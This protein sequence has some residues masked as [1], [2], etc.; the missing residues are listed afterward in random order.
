[1]TDD[2]ADA[3]P[4]GRGAGRHGPHRPALD[5]A[6]AGCR[7]A[8]RRT[9]ARVAL[10]AR[11]RVAP[12]PDA[13]VA[14]AADP[15]AADRQPRRDRAAH[16][17]HGAAGSGSA[18]IG[19]HEAGRPAAGRGRPGR[20]RCLDY[21]DADAILDA[22]RRARRRRDPPRLRLPGRE[23]RRSPRP[24]SMPGWPG[25]GR[26][27]PPSRRWATRRRRGARPSAHGVPVVPGYDG[28]AQDD[29]T[30]AGRGGAR[31]AIPLLVK[32][33][34]GGGGKGMRVVRDADAPAGGAGVS[35]ARGAA[36]PSATIGSSWSAARAARATSRSR[37]CSTRHGHGVHLGE[38]DCSAQR[39]HQKI[40][41]ES[42][43][44]SVDA[45][46]ARAARGG[47]AAGGGARSAT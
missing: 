1:M 7:R 38:R 34:A 44:P 32:P 22:A 33:A 41:E 27:R 39:R 18:T 2:D 29:A 8:G 24:W 43:G 16:R 40:I 9:R 12:A 45:R 42:P 17:A 30:L 20:S 37:S 3:T 11:R 6:T 15:R 4:G 13:G 36:A 21:L 35:A 5:C 14:A 28:D 31:S 46:A 47:R 25:S 23:R 10:V 26:R 19:V